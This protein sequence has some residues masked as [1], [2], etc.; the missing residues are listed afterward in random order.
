MWW[1]NQVFLQNHTNVFQ[2]HTKLSP[3]LQSL[4]DSCMEIQLQNS[5]SCTESSCPMFVATPGVEALHQY[6]ELLQN[7]TNN[8]GRLLCLWCVL[9]LEFSK[10][11]SEIMT[12]N[13]VL[14]L[15]SMENMDILTLF[16]IRPF[17]ELLRMH[18]QCHCTSSL[19]QVYKCTHTL[20]NCHAF[21]G[22]RNYGPTVQ[23]MSTVCGAVRGPPGTV[24]LTIV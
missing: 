16:K 4:I 2:S 9:L 12:W 14:I 24:S 22:N 20:R 6:A 5:T 8:I 10:L 1:W 11:V 19:V 3:L 23:H 21:S 7:E 13:V 17:Q 15:Y 18:Q